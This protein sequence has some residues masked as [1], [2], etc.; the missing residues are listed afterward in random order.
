MSGFD[1][2]EEAYRVVITWP[3]PQ[4]G[5]RQVSVS[6]RR[7]GIQDVVRWR[8]LRQRDVPWGVV[9][10]VHQVPAGPGQASVVLQTSSGPV[11]VLVEGDDELASVL[12]DEL[13]RARQRSRSRSPMSAGRVLRS[14]RASC[15]SDQELDGRHPERPASRR[16]P[17]SS[18]P[19]RAPTTGTLRCYTVRSQVDREVF[20]SIEP[21]W[22]GVSRLLVTLALSGTAL[23]GLATLCATVGVLLTVASPMTALP[24]LGLGLGSVMILLGGAGLTAVHWP[25]RSRPWSFSLSSRGLGVGER[26]IGWSE[27]AD[28]VVDEGAGEGMRVVVRTRAPAGSGSVTLAHS[29]PPLD[30]GLLQARIVAVR[31]HHDS[32]ACHPVA[33]EAMHALLGAAASKA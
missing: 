22:E 5:E 27:V 11:Q 13:D 1:R 14:V 20:A 12:V 10:Q 18:L 9:E 25:G 30:A 16:L 32:G 17:R 3:R 23:V 6:G 15:A 21:A 29:L 33:P 26:L 2:R 28:V 7:V 19:T 31:E 4:G 24:P 8:T